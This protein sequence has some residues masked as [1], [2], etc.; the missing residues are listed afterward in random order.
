MSEENNTAQDQPNEVENNATPIVGDELKECKDKYLRLL[1]EM[2]NMRKRMQKEKQESVRFAIDN[3]IADFLGPLDNLEN[4]LGFAEKMSEETRNWAMGF[5][6]ILNQFKEVL[7]NNGVVTFK[8]EGTSF[9]PHK[10][11]AVETEE[12]T[13]HK[14]GTVIKEFVRGYKSGERIVRPAR[15]KVAKAP[16]KE[17]STPSTDTKINQINNN[18]KELSS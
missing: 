4:A 8:S 11:E 13:K 2:E 15:V 14:E 12:T 1:A 10:H 9:D 7:S 17:D 3:V 18:D 6:M 5:Q 16:A